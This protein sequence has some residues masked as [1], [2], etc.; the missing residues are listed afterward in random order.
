MNGS[1]FSRSRG[2]LLGVVL[3]AVFA[4]AGLFASSASAELPP[5]TSTDV[6]LGDSLAFGYSQQLFNE[7]L[8]GGELAN[9][10]EHGY[11]NF[12]YNKM[13]PKENGIR[14]VNLGCPG[15]TTD[16]LIGN[17]PLAAALEANPALKGPGGQKVHGEAPCAYHTEHGLPLHREYGGSKSQLEALAE[18]YEESALTGKPVTTITLNIGAND[19]LHQVKACE[20]FGKTEAIREFTEGHITAGEI[21]AVA[22]K[23]AR[24]CILAEAPKLFEHILVNESGMLA[25]I[26]TPQTEGGLGFLG[27]I[28]VQGGYDPFGYVFSLEEEALPGSNLLAAKLNEAEAGAVAPFGACFANPQPVF[29]PTIVLGTKQVKRAGEGL[30]KQRLEKLTNMTNFTETTIAGH[31]LKFGEKEVEVLPGVKTSADGPDIHPTPA[32]YQSLATVMQRAC[33]L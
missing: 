6:G 25:F 15:E 4:I 13:K 1:T 30:E 18:T 8:T 11:V 9:N 14:L 32:G 28:V 22:E 26:R 20:E 12:Y 17:G 19:E 7:H 3:V 29:N 10:F 23:F 33:G 24:G 16:S 27:K 2:R 21:K 5:V 31:T